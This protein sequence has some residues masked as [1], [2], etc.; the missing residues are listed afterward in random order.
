MLRSEQI[1]ETVWQERRSL[2]KWQAK[3]GL[4]EPTSQ[5]T[6]PGRSAA[7]ATTKK[8]KV[9]WSQAEG[10]HYGTAL[11]LLQD[12]HILNHT[13]NR[14]LVGRYG[15]RTLANDASGQ[16][17]DGVHLGNDQSSCYS[18]RGDT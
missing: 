18:A 14:T 7:P 4:S 17:A 16:G 9:L 13:L 12:Q 5:P 10:A 2:Q 15:Q 8:K 1:K 3:M 6:S 11:V